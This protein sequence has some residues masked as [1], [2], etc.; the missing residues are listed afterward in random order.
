MLGEYT[1]DVLS[2]DP[3]VDGRHQRPLLQKTSFERC[4]CVLQA[5]VSLGWRR[6]SS[7]SCRSE[8]AQRI[9]S[10]QELLRSVESVLSI[11]YRSLIRGIAQP[12]LLCHKEPAQGT[13]APSKGLWVP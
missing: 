8:S 11:Q 12:A 6:K 7:P 5:S 4:T 3:R 1:G 2:A 13:N 10:L 9:S